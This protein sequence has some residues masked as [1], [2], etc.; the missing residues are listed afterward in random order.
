MLLKYSLI[1]AGNHWLRTANGHSWLL[2]V[3]HRYEWL[4]WQATANWCSFST[5]QLACAARHLAPSKVTIRRHATQS[6]G[7]L[8]QVALGRDIPNVLRAVLRAS[9]KKATH[10][11]ANMASEYFL[12]PQLRISKPES[13]KYLSQMRSRKAWC[14][15]YKM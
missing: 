4:V 2:M 9:G 6:V 10:G 3:I 12:Q 11:L 8:D 5:K 14:M 15:T 1:H 13:K 7:I